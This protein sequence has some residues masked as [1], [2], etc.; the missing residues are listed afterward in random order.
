MPLSPPA[1]RESLHTRRITLEGYQ[2]DDGLFDVEAH[3]VDLKSE[4]FTTE[5]RGRVEKGEPLHEMR[6][7]VTYDERMEILACEAA[8]EHSPY[9]ACPSA[10]PAFARLVGLRMR[11]GFL[12]EAAA[13]VGGAVGCTHLRE[14]LQQV[15]TTAF[16]TAGPVLSRRRVRDGS[17]GSSPRLIDTCLAYAADGDLV[18]RRWPDLARRRE[19]EAAD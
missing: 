1:R 14:L 12:K 9:E 7:R 5:E 10:A 15:A 19:Q 11:P 13:R 4:G 16:Q 17:D 3:L 2:R 18:A 8:T 6:L